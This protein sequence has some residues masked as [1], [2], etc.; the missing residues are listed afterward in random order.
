MMIVAGGRLVFLPP[1]PVLI[2][3]RVYAPERNF[4]ENVLML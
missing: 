3:P 1:D 2:G 4:A